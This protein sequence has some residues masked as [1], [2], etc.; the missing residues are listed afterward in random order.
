MPMAIAAAESLSL[1]IVTGPEYERL[2]VIVGVAI[3]LGILGYAVT[4]V[5]IHRD[6][7]RPWRSSLLATGALL[8]WF[9]LSYLLGTTYIESRA[10]ERADAA[11]P[12]AAEALE[13]WQE[14][15]L[16]AGALGEPGLRPDEI[17]RLV[18]TMD[19]AHRPSGQELRVGRVERHVVTGE[20]ITFAVYWKVGA[21]YSCR[22]DAGEAPLF[23]AMRTP[24][25]PPA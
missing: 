11:R 22:V 17:D 24:E 12:E 15:D 10:V 9:A 4:L 16:A 21:G 13:R 18:A 1:P 3:G 20:R 6:E 2:V 5:R 14:D 25:A 7:P 23:R 8:G 19:L